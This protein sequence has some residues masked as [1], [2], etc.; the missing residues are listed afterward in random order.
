[1]TGLGFAGLGLR[2]LPVHELWPRIRLACHTWR[3]CF[4]SS[5]AEPVRESRFGLLMLL[6]GRI[7]FCNDEPCV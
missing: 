1:M 6:Q 2:Q 4:L 7:R 3:E 5:K